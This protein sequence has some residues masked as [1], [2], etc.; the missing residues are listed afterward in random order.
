MHDDRH[1][2]KRHRQLRF[3]LIGLLSGT[4]LCAILFTAVANRSLSTVDYVNTDFVVFWHTGKILAA[5]DNPYDPFVWI[6]SQQSV[7]SVLLPKTRFL[8]P[9][10]TAF[11][12]LPL[13][14]LSLP[15]AYYFWIIMSQCLVAISLRLLLV[16]EKVTCYP[17]LI[18]P[19]L[20]GIMLFRPTL[21]IVQ[22]G[23]MSGVLL[24]IICGVIYLWERGDYR[25]GGVILSLL[26]IKPNIGLPMI[27]ILTV[28]LLF[29]RRKAALTACLSACFALIVLTMLYNPY[30]IGE[31]LQAGR[32]QM[33]E[34]LMQTPTIPG[35]AARLIRSSGMQALIL[36]GAVGGVILMVSGAFLWR[37]RDSIND[38]MAICL[39]IIVTLMLTPYAWPYDQLLLIVPFVTVMTMM[40]HGGYPYLLFASLFI[41]VDAIAFVLLKIS[42]AAQTENYSVILTLLALCLLVW[43]IRREFTDGQRCRKLFEI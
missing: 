21:L 37:H 25:M 14:L 33:S 18:L 32:S 36:G 8:Y 26:I 23:Q 1:L 43:Q 15:T 5:G 2:A 40:M 34:F 41:V 10:M 39:A 24:L 6:S 22:N 7:G 28:W 13:G 17:H 31:F 16:T 20:A 35:C 30:W 29:K 19:I 11:L 9:L 12:F 42:S 38:R 4:L 27:V 3:K